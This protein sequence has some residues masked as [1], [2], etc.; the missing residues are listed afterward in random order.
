MGKVVEPDLE[1]IEQCF[2]SFTATFHALFTHIF[3]AVIIGYR[4]SFKIVRI[5]FS[6]YIFLAVAAAF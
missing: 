3:C 2:A 1:V 5:N 4:N 6:T